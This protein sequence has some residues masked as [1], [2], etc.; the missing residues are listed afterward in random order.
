MAGGGTGAVG[1][2]SGGVGG[3]PGAAG[4]GPGGVG[5]G[6]GGAGLVP[7]AGGAGG[8]GARPYKPGKSELLSCLGI[9]SRPACLYYNNTTIFYH[10]S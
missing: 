9:H 3:G 8:V 5:G 10:P 7:G 6:P 1:G 2:G 4:G